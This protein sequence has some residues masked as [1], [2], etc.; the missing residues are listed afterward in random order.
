VSRR[1][2]F[3]NG[4]PVAKATLLAGSE[5]LLAVSRHALRTSRHRLASSFLH[6]ADSSHRMIDTAGR[7]DCTRVQL[8]KSRENYTQLLDYG[9]ATRRADQTVAAG[10]GHEPR[11][12]PA[13]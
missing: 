9:K 1:H 3:D 4:F 6:L 10:A 2:P 8:R 7:C 13:R 12:R 5:V 11:A